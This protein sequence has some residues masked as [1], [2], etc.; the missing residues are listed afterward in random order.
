VYKPPLATAGPGVLCSKND[1]NEDEAGKA[2]RS[3]QRR[4]DETN[5]GVSKEARREGRGTIKGKSIEGGRHGARELRE[6]LATGEGCHTQL[7]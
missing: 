5:K 1:M 2:L 3:G 6:R 7:H 4:Q